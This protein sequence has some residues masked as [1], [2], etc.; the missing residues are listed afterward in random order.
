MWHEKISTILMRNLYGKITCVRTVDCH[1]KLRFWVWT[2]QKHT[3]V[4]R[5][6]NQLVSYKAGCLTKYL[7][8]S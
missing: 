7:R 3:L 8:I 4:R 2:A 5:K 1:I 6:M